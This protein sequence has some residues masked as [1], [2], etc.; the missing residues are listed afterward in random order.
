MRRVVLRMPR[1]QELFPEVD[2]MLRPARFVRKPLRL[3][4]APLTE[5]HPGYLELDRQVPTDH[6]AR[7]VRSL[8]EEL[9][10]TAFFLG[11]QT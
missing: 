7:Q 10:L 11:Q 3:I 5:D 4:R 6:L 8:V 9:D 2:A 1:R